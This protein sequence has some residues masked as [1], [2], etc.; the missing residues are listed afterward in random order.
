M[1]S[2]WSVLF[3]TPTYALAVRDW[4]PGIAGSIL[5]PT[6]GGFAVGGLLVGWLHIRRHG[7]FYIPSLVVYLVFPATL[8]ALAYLSTSASS[9]ALYVLVVFLN[10][11]VTGAALNYTLA[12]LL[13]LTPASTHYVATSLI[14]TFRGFAGSFGSAVGGGL[15]VRVLRQS[16]QAGFEDA[17]FGGKKEGLVRRLLG[18]P[19]LVG[20]LEGVEKRV[21]VRGYEEALRSL[22]LAGAGLALLMVLVQAGTGWR[23]AGEEKVIQDE[24]EDLVSRREGDA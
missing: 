24:A 20:Q 10:G 1:M 18:S 12:H 7:S 2:R 8:V 22:F 23:G 5:I 16:L 9:P 21:A 14:A 15:F 19:A 17:G 13:H 4:S 11:F 6:N 3:Y